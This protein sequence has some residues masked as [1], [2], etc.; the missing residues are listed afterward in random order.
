MPKKDLWGITLGTAVISGW[1]GH[2]LYCLS[3]DQFQ[4]I[5]IFHF[6]LQSFLSTGLFITA[7]DS[8]HGSLAPRYPLIN[9]LL[10]KLAIFLYAAFPFQKL[11]RN[12][13][14]H[15]DAPATFDD[16]DYTGAK[17]EGMV[18]WIFN[19]VRNYYGLREFLLMHIH[20]F[21]ILYVGESILKLFVFFAFPAWLSA[22]QLFFFGTYLPHRNFQ[23]AQGLKARSNNFPVWLSLLT[24]YHFGYHREHHDHP[25]LAWWQLPKVRW[26]K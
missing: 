7:H 2:L 4:P 12:H 16:P 11:K 26:S 24:C 25:E 19:F 3:F 5:W 22:F 6:F 18:R 10:G 9:D 21:V 15:H 23:G 20:V 17:H 1:L 8:M 13:F 14:K